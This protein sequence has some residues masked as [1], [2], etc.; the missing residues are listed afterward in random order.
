MSNIIRLLSVSF[1]LIYFGTSLYGMNNRYETESESSDEESEDECTTD[2]GRVKDKYRDGGYVKETLINAAKTMTCWTDEDGKEIHIM[3][4]RRAYEK[5]FRDCDKEFL[6]EIVN[7]TSGKGTPLYCLID[8]VGG[9]NALLSRKIVDYYSDLGEKGLKCIGCEDN[10]PFESITNGL[11]LPVRQHAEDSCCKF[12]EYENEFKNACTVLPDLFRV[13]GKYAVKAA[14]AASADLAGFEINGIHVPNFYIAFRDAEDHSIIG[15]LIYF[16]F[17]CVFK[18][19]ESD[20]KDQFFR[21]S[22]EYLEKILEIYSRNM[23]D[24][25]NEKVKRH[26]FIDY[27]GDAKASLVRCAKVMLGKSFDGFGPNKEFSRD[28]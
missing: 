8:G 20:G 5:I 27:S 6:I 13:F 19:I 16:T 14:K 23:W 12:S 17:F 22:R 9:R 2:F 11:L 10:N 18:D 28:D 4:D 26:K 25:V 7:D 24:D 21:K 15:Y 3:G 1:C